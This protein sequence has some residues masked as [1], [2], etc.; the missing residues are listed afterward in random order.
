LNGWNN[1]ERWFDVSKTHGGALSNAILSSKQH[2]QM[3]LPTLGMHMQCSL[4]MKLQITT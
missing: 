1:K 3:A 2:Q 4:Q